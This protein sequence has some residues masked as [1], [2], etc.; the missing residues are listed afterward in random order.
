MAVNEVEKAKLG[1]WEF[2]IENMTRRAF[3]NYI[4]R[5]AISETFYCLWILPLSMGDLNMPRLKRPI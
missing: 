5:S 3:G 1:E 2:R 4:H